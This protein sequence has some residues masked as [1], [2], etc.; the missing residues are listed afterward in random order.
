MDAP[1]PPEAK[2]CVVKLNV[3]KRD[4]RTIEEVQQEL[5]ARKEPRRQQPVQQGDD[6]RT[7][8]H[9]GMGLAPQQL[10]GDAP[11]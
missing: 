3:H 10:E 2:D 9:Q 4:L 6:G 5:K 11:P 7:A 8:P 1:P